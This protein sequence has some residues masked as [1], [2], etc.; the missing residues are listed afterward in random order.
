M[1]ADNPIDPIHQFEISKIDTVKGEELFLTI[2]SHI[3]E[4]AVN[5]L[6]SYRAGSINVINMRSYLWIFGYYGLLF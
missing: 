2:D 1:A 6:K 4:Y 3:Q 5:L